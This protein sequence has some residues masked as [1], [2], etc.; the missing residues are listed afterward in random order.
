MNKKASVR[1]IFI[2]KW[3]KK[4]VMKIKLKWNTMINNFKEWERH[5]QPVFCLN[6]K[7]LWF[8]AFRI[9]SGSSVQSTAQH[10]E[11][12]NDLFVT[13]FWPITSGALSLQTPASY[14][15]LVLFGGDLLTYLTDLAHLI[16]L[17]LQEIIW[18]NTQ[19]GPRNRK[20][21]NWQKNDAV[22][23]GFFS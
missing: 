13:S 16:H 1:F 4:Q 9:L 10:T 21:Y 18:Q 7:G 20:R 17:L 19:N 22:S 5:F 11:G 6:K 12:G 14:R 15:T 23:I 3:K 8:T 2:Q